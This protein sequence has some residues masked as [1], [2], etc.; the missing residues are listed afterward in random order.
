MTGSTLIDYQNFEDAPVLG[1]LKVWWLIEGV[2]VHKGWL[3]PALGD[4]S[5]E[6]RND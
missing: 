5:Y 3:M 2:W 6:F 4:P 1:A